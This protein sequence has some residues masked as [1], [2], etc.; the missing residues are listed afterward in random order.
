M[1]GNEAAEHAF[2]VC[3]MLQERELTE[4]EAF[5]VVATALANLLT[6]IPKK[7]LTPDQ[8][9]AALAQLCDSVRQQVAAVQQAT[10]AV[11]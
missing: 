8:L 5:A 2:A 1:T 6:I 7:P 4:V 11:R 3:A 10:A 9:E